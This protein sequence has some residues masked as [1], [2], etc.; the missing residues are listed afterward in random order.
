M[1]KTYRHLE[2]SIRAVGDH[3]L[4][5]VVSATHVAEGVANFIEGKDLAWKD[6]FDVAF[7]EKLKDLGQQPCQSVSQGCLC[8]VDIDANYLAIVDS[9]KLS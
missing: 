6:G 9:G 1:P 2:I 7:I 4:A 3:H 8:P 5:N